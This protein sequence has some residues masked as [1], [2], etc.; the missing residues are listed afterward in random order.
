MGTDNQDFFL[1]LP[2][3]LGGYD[4]I[5]AV[6]DR[7]TKSTH[8]IPVQVKYTIEKSTQFYLSHIVR[9]HGV[10]TSTVFDRGAL[11]T[12]HF[13]R[14]L[15]HDLVTLY[16]ITMFHLIQTGSLSRQFKCS[17]TCFED[18]WLTLVLDKINTCPYQ[19]FLIIRVIAPVFRWTHLRHYMVDGAHIWLVDIIMLR[20]TL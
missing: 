7:L 5:L 1:G 10:P 2:T 3:T 17:R 9:L 18:M 11:F 19:S 12:S 8:F 15:Q 14:G 6:V 20:W 13:W 16:M 4:V